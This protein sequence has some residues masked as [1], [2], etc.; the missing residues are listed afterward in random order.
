MELNP[1]PRFIQIVGDDGFTRFIRSEDEKKRRREE[2]QSN[3]IMKEKVCQ[4]CG[5]TYIPKF[6]HG[7]RRWESSKYCCQTCSQ[8]A[9]NS[10]QEHKD[11]KNAKRRGNTELHR[12]EHERRI[13]LHGGTRWQV[14]TPK[15]RE[16]ARERNRKRY[17][18]LYGHD[19][20]YTSD[21]KA[22]AQSQRSRRRYEKNKLVL[23][24]EEQAACR[25]IRAKKDELI[26]KTGKK[27][28][29]D[30]IL[31][32]KRG[33]HEHPDNLLIITA[34]ANLFWGPKIKCCPWPKPDNWDEP[35]WEP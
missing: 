32:L 25:S 15:F 11:K 23:T 30:H 6:Q 4:Q 7:T 27:L 3:K 10:R 17:S 5:K 22:N 21:R 26:M 19:E 9:R 29:V 16:Q 1:S 2:A 12:R 35:A 8:K 33:G 18:R 13:E 20:A 24:P 34:A 14:G 28:H 31:P